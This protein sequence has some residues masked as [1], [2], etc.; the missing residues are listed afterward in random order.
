MQA[1]LPKKLPETSVQLKSI[2]EYR[3]LLE[4][5][6]F[7][8]V[9]TE[10]PNFEWQEFAKSVTGKEIMLQYGSPIFQVKLEEKFMN[11]S[12][13]RGKRPLL[14]HT[15]ASDYPNPPKYLVLWCEKPSDCGGGKTTLA[16]VQGFL[17]TLTEEEKKKLME[18]R[19]YF[20]A[21]GG[22]HANR[23]EGAIHNILSFSG[24]KPILRFSCNYIKHGDYSP[25]PENLKPFTPEPFLGEISDRFIEYY[26]ENHLA[27]RMEKYSCLLW[28]NECMAHSRTTYTDL[29]RKLERI[30]LA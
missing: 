6:H 28:D 15:E 24:D 14:P 23:T 27:I 19:H 26:E 3:K 7:I 29:S 18:T 12:D 2:A 1:V 22:I 8:Y 11:L 16:Y 13:A 5:N 21:T 4:R 9:E 30:F 20:G 25:D 17:D 10:E